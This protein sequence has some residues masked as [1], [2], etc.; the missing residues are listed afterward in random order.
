MATVLVNGA[1]RL[2]GRRIVELAA[3]DPEGPTIVPVDRDTA[4]DASLGGPIDLVLLAPGA[5]P[6]RGGSSLGGVD[7]VTASSLLAAVEGLDVRHVV[8]LSSAMVYGAWR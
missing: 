7:L 1:G 5:G 2:L 4:I 6:D 3:A 8:V